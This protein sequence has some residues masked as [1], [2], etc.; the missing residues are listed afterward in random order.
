MLKC[1]RLAPFLWILVLLLFAFN[2]MLIGLIHFPHCPLASTLP[3]P[4]IGAHGLR[5]N[6]CPQYRGPYPNGVPSLQRSPA[7]VSIITRGDDP[8]FQSTNS[9]YGEK[10]KFKY[11]VGSIFSSLA[12]PI[13]LDSFFDGVN[14]DM[15]SEDLE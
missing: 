4:S 3:N 6:V 14:I 8:E 12:C 1:F 7:M 5:S 15:G 11:I 10:P 13:F 9:T 2:H